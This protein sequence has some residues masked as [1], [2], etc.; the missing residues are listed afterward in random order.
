[1]ETKEELKK[2]L[3]ELTKQEI[4]LIEKRY[5]NAT[6]KIFKEIDTIHQKR[7]DIWRIITQIN[8][9]EIQE[10]GHY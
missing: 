10:R 9:K 8:E 3:I 1:M 6:S 7:M 4:V 5:K 2:N